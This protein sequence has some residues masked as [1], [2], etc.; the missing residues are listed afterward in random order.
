MVAHLYILKC[1]N[2]K[3][4]TGSTKHL[5]LR[6]NQHRNGEGANFTRKNLP[7]KLVYTERYNRI[8][9]AFAREKQIQNW[10]SAKKEALI[11]RNI[12]ALKDASQCQNDSH[13][14]NYHK[15]K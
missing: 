6:L 15:D 13:S 5:E 10:S 4:Y 11:S 9:E 12:N 14:D 7:I 3:Y 8:D 1:A 2:G